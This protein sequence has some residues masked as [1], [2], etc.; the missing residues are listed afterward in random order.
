MKGVPVSSLVPGS[1]FDQPVYLDTSYI[2][3][4]PDSPVTQELVNRLR[5]WKYG[6]IATDGKPKD[7]PGYLSQA[8]S[9]SVGP[10]TIDEGL[11][12]NAQVEAARKFH[13][14][15]TIF[16]DGLFAKYSL[17]GLLNLAQVTEW[18]KKA[19]QMVHEGRDFLLG[20]LDVG[21]DGD[22]YLI[23]H[24][25][26]STI[27]ALAI[28]DFM[29][30][31]PHRLIELGQAC[32]L[33]E[34]GMLKLPPDLRRTSKSLSPEERKAMSTHTILGYRIL[35]GFSAPENV[36][37]AALEHHERI[38]GSGYPR[39][40][41]APK[42]TD[43]A[44]IIGVVCSYDAMLSRRPYRPGSLDGHAT[45]RDL[46]QKNRKQY[47][48]KILKALVYTLSVYPVGT[49]V[50]LS[51][52]SR[53]IVV[54]TDPTRPRSPVVRVVLDPAG[55]RLVD[56]PMVQVSDTDGL[57]ISGVLSAEDAL[58]VKDQN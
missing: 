33:H 50:Q 55:K 51:N 28:G 19:I 29:K 54:K 3:L 47:D 48:E 43:Y 24:A 7:A 11:Q 2:L 26:N 37:L 17:E 45:I 1:Y 34:I 25:V 27:L 13:A 49:A 46:A 22:R 23:T 4:T 12:Q 5:K 36:A 14:D 8:N 30:A 42:I 32:L 52:N 18:I 21:A 41:S 31:P 35:K 56:P 39:A 16:A 40:L 58:Q 57:T 20:F 15:F 38:D 44:L 9:G 10:Q 6:D 53:G